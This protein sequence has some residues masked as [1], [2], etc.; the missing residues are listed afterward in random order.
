MSFIILSLFSSSDGFGGI[1]PDVITSNTAPKKV[2]K[3][4]ELTVIS[5]DGVLVLE[6]FFEKL[7]KEI[8]F[9]SQYIKDDRK[10][11][12]IH[13]GGGTPNAISLKYIERVTDKIKECFDLS[14][15]YEMAIECS[16]AHLDFKHVELLKNF[17][18]N[19]ISLGIQDFDDKVLDAISVDLSDGKAGDYLLI[20]GS[21]SYKRIMIYNLGDK[22]KLTNDKMREFGSKLYSLANSKKVKSMTMDTKSFWN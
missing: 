12:Q 4:D 20:P 17:G 22:N 1:G 13:W 8:E 6:K 16:P 5:E 18:F 3:K 21:S 19:R 14:D 9:V 10:L 2:L 15:E 11:T 7:P